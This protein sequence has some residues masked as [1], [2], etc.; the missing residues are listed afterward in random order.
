M[1]EVK[2][3]GPKTVVFT[4]QGISYILDMLT[5][6]PWRLANPLI[7]DIMSQLKAQEGDNCGPDVNRSGEITAGRG[8]SSPCD[9]RISPVETLPT[10]HRAEGVGGYS[11]DD[12]TPAR[13]GT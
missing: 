3:N 2:L 7:S 10:D 1:N 9:S 13:A 12:I 6:C 8:N 5:N 4:P 11:S